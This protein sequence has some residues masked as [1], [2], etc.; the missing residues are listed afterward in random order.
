MVGYQSLLG[1][2]VALPDTRALQDS[3]L[4]DQLFVVVRL[5]EGGMEHSLSAVQ[6][7][8]SITVLVLTKLPT[9]LYHHKI[10][11]IVLYAQCTCSIQ[12]CDL[13]AAFLALSDSC[14]IREHKLFSKGHYN[15]MS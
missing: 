12:G 7:I 13:H 4:L 6:V 11:C 10:V 8:K 5:L 15:K 2:L 1:W 9:L 14:Q 3:L